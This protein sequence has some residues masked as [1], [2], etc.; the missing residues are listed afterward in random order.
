M[1]DA[2]EETLA[3][4]GVTH[5]VR[6]G[7]SV[8][9]PARPFTATIQAYLA[10]VRSQGFTD[11]PE[12]LGYD[13]EG[14]E[15]LSF[16]AGEVPVDPLP[17]HATASESMETLA[18]LIRR[19]HEAA[20]GWTP[21]AD[22]VW[23]GVPGVRP[24]G[25]IPLFDRPELV[26]HMD[27]CPGNI[28]FSDERPTAL[29]DFDLARPTTRVADLANALYWWAPLLDPVDRAPSLVEADVPARV[30]AF[31]DAYGMTAE[32][33]A[34][35]IP[36]ANRMVANFALT[37]RAAA[38][39]DPVFRRWWDEGLDDQMPRAVAWLTAESSALQGAL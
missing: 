24:A 19:L 37:S 1:E 11:C 30:R 25:V 35:L 3:S 21:P 4:G 27:Y 7:P 22:A 12:P 34:Q 14:R 8:R 13:A 26:S 9:R 10:H 18:V 32:Q 33:R 2:V 39:V 15:V 31:A 28:V 20:D 17:A 29:I 6:I 16:V 38:E 23:G 36:V 5:V